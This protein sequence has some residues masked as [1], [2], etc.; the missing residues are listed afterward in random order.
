LSDR[1]WVDA[2]WRFI[3]IDIEGLDHEFLSD[4]DLVELAPDVVAVERFLP[5]GVS[6]CEKDT[7]LANSCELVSGMRRRNFSLQS[8]CGPTLIFVRIESRK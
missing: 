2:P 8:I 7:F 4:L 3:S 6:D 5:R 1:A